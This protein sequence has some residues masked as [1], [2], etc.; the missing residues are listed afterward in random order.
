MKLND[1]FLKKTK[2]KR[3]IVRVDFNVEVKGEEIVD[4]FRIKACLKTIDLILKEKPKRIILISH[5]GQPKEEEKW[6]KDFSLY[7]VY[8]YLK[9]IY[10][11][12]VFFF[13]EKE[14]EKLDQKDY[15]EGSLILVENIR[16]YKGEEENDKKFAKKLASLGDIYIN[17]AFSAS[18]RE[19]ASLLG[20]TEFLPSYLGF[21]FQ[22]EILNLKKIKENYQEPFVI[23][24]GGAKIKDKLPLI[25]NFL[26]K[27]NY[28]LLGGGIA[29]TILKAWGFSIG[30]SFYEEEM[31]EKAK[32]LGSKKAEMILP[33]DFWVLDSL[34]RKKKRALGEV[35][36]NDIILDIGPVAS[37]FY[38]KI[39]K[40]AKTILFNGPLGKIEEKDF[41]EGT[42][43][44]LEAILE[45]QDAFTVIGGGDTL[46]AF[47]I[48][49]LKIQKENIFL[50][51]GGG[52]MLKYLAGEKFKAL[53][54]I[55]NEIK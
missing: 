11:E 50:S 30:Q 5:F 47:K 14:I 21:L 40:K 10:Q 37:G 25:E 48:L 12:K 29:N 38:Q 52:A 24:L 31:I 2:G 19:S 17:E 26:E 45:N 7:P 43:K 9:R 55:L 32:N 54:A 51:T 3:V 27:A 44:V 28:L 53:E 42:K 33:G 13:Q 4:D 35:K 23:I 20:I 1:D 6:T 39:I 16:F 34:K 46:K 49:G 15:P 8:L 18:H 41:Q 22:E 36:K